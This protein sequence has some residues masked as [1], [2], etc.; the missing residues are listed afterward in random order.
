ML[1]KAKGII[2]ADQEKK[3]AHPLQ[4]APK[5]KAEPCNDHGPAIEHDDYGAPTKEPKG[6]LEKVYQR[7]LKLLE[8]EVIDIYHAN[9]PHDTYVDVFQALRK[10][11][12]YIF[13]L[14]KPDRH[15]P[16]YEKF[17]GKPLGDIKFFPDRP[18]DVKYRQIIK[19][20]AELI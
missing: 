8:S 18:S 13:P 5:P 20:L 4:D 2:E 6:N 10:I 9:F 19:M 16:L 3:L 1:K 15:K 7:R 14:E 17:T 11:A 12:E